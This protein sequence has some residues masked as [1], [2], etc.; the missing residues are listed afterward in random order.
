MCYEKYTRFI[1]GCRD[2]ES[3][4]CDFATAIDHPFWLKLRC[5][6]YSNDH[7]APASAC[8]LRFYCAKSRDAKYLNDLWRRGENAT[9]E[10]N[11]IIQL[12]RSLTAMLE[13]A[14]QKNVPDHVCK[15]HP[16]FMAMSY[17][18]AFRSKFNRRNRLVH[19]CS[20]LKQCIYEVKR[21]YDSYGAPN[22]PDGG[23]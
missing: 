10:L 2:V 7:L 21:F 18:L 5:P 13:D 12:E 17:E 19:E 22:A 6:D 16:Q 4:L 15:R 14:R 9:G 20:I 23:M 8:S 3:T 11:S 1:C